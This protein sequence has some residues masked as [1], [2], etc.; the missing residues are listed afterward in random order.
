MYTAEQRKAITRGIQNDAFDYRSLTDHLRNNNLQRL[1]EKQ[2]FRTNLGYVAIYK[3]IKSQSIC[4]HKTSVVFTAESSGGDNPVEEIKMMQSLMQ[5]DGKHIRAAYI[6]QL[7]DSWV[8]RADGYSMIHYLSEWGGD[9]LFSIIESSWS[10]GRSMSESL[11]R[12]IFLQIIL[13]LN[14]LHCNRF[15]AHRDL[16]PENM[17]FD[18]K[19]QTLKFIDFGTSCYDKKEGPDRKMHFVRHRQPKGSPMYMAPENGPYSYPPKS[20]SLDLTYIGSQT[21]VYACGITLF[22]MLCGFP[23]YSIDGKEHRGRIM[24]R[25]GN[26]RQLMSTYTVRLSEYAL[27]LLNGMLAPAESR[28]ETSQILLHPWMRSVNFI[29]A[30]L[31]PSVPPPDGA[32]HTPGT[33]TDAPET[34]NAP[35]NYLR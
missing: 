24:I 6:P 32:A 8:I 19:T 22:M 28:I 1:R 15:I 18:S 3:D 7:L 27:D 2:G 11:C 16:K 25:S 23:P 4:V 33:N 26:F 14:D 30:V 29:A 35:N 13:A 10:E 12:N 21:D 31:Q 34:A 9:E 17:V 20:N 5:T